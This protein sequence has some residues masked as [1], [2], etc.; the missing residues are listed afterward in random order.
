MSELVWDIKEVKR[1][2]KKSLVE[3]NIAMLL[4][5]LFAVFYINMGWSLS[6]F[7]GLACLAIWF[8]AGLS[9]YTLITGNTTGTKTNKQVQAFDRQRA[10]DKSWKRKRI[11]EVILFSVLGVVCTLLIFPIDLSDESL[12]YINVIPFM[13][14]WFGAN[15][16]S[17]IRIINL[18]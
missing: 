14:A 17:I 4:I 5:F 8:F 10:G 1:L 13:G 16:G 7:F 2:K 3:L 15:L 12:R 11:T 6:L 18:E 9:L